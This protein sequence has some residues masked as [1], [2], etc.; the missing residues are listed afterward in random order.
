MKHLPYS[1]VEIH[2][3]LKCIQMY[4]ITI[5]YVV[6]FSTFFFYQVILSSQGITIQILCSVYAKKY[7]T[8][9]PGPEKHFLS[10]KLNFNQKLDLGLSYEI[11]SFEDLKVIP[12]TS[13]IM[14]YS[15][16]YTRFSGIFFF[17]SSIF[18]FIECFE[19]S[20]LLIF[21]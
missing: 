2:N 6:Q 13:Q 10:R 8:L 15:T 19:L 9:T 17:S 12:V 18:L 14:E 16:I 7:T 11:S 21:L 1:E 5:N 3:F 20:T 4:R